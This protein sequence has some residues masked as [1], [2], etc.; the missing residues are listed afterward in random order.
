MLAYPV[1][2]T[3]AKGSG[4]FVVTFCDIPEAIT[5]GETVEEALAMAAEALESAMDFYFE[6]KR[7][8]PMP[9]PAKQRQHVVEL[10]LSLSAKVLL[11]NEMARQQVRPAE[12]AR[13]LQTT[14]QD[15]N[16]L[17]NLHHTSKIDGIA[18]AMKALGKTLEIRAV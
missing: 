18:G 11:L 2:L 17:T 9:S 1:R 6:D 5:Q 14:P 16:R 15:I 8:V 3:P 13:R 12:L 4:G 10:P 7:P